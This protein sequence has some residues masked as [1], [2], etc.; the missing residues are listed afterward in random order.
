MAER[1]KKQKQKK[2]SKT[3][4][5]SSMDSRSDVNLKQEKYQRIL[6]LEI[7]LDKQLKTKQNKKEREREIFTTPGEKKIIF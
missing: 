7:I 6:Y 1:Q 5:H 2:L 3:N 4:E